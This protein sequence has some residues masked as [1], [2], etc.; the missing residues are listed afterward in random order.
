MHPGT[1][2][3]VGKHRKKPFRMGDYIASYTLDNKASLAILLELAKQIKNPPV[4]VYLVASAKEEVGAI[5]ALYFT[6]RTRLDALIA[7]EICPLAPEYPIESG[8]KPVLLSQDGYGIYDEGLNAEL[9]KASQRVNV[10]IQSAIIRGFGS[11]ASIAMKFG[12]ISRAACLS[13][14]TQNTHGFEIAHLG[15]ISHCTSIL[16]SYCQG[17]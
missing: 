11:D 5:G 14:P 12:H 13:F 3:V 6:N 4:T 7:L 16:L 10:S 2:V 1:R 15:A 9:R 8:E 17:L